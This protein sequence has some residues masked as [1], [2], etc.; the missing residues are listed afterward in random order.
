[1]G[2]NVVLFG[3]THVPLCLEEEGVLYLNPGSL[4]SPRG[5]SHA[6]YAILEIEKGRAAATLMDYSKFN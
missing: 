2:A 1:M 5:G 3:H 6:S 4:T